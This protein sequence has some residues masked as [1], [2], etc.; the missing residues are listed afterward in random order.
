M[1]LA[2]RFY[3][4]MNDPDRIEPQ[5]GQYVSAACFEDYALN[6]FVRKNLTAHNC[7][8]YDGQ[9]R[10]PK[11]AE[12]DVVIQ[13]VF[14]RL[15]SRYDDATSGVGWDRGFVGAETY[16]SDDLVREHVDLTENAKEA[17]LEDIIGELPDRT[18]S[19]I[20]PYRARVHSVYSWSWDK[21]VDVVKHKRRYFFDV[22]N[23]ALLDEEISPHQLLA[24]VANKC[25]QA[26]MLR[27]L[28]IG[29]EFFR[30]RPSEKDQHFDTPLDLGP[31][32]KEYAAQNRMSPAGIPMF[33]G[34]A[35]N[36]T[37][38]AETLNRLKDPHSMALFALGREVTVLDLT[39]AP[40]ISIFDSRRQSLYDWAIFMHR[41]RR[42]LSKKIE[43]DNRVHIEY[44]P[45]Q[46]VTEYFR[47][48]LRAR[49]G[50]LIDG[51]LYQ[52]ATH[53]KGKCIALF[54][55]SDD[56]EPLAQ[57]QVD[58]A[59]GHLLQLLSVAQQYGSK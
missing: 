32:P 48:F 43:K 1:G 51:I 26:R 31:A 23:E 38:Q 52:S 34:A 25:R 21:L 37:A 6:K 45:T 4:E 9:G 28:P 30:C 44:I 59:S 40:I 14:E 3:E 57:K 24:T 11:G 20:D 17:L 8:Y 53:T 58:P 18:W 13:F 49:G 7:S 22:S 55:D 56:V 2:K 33:Y 19:E 36:E 39:T 27:K 50:K 12:L 47:T 41:F 29:S 5:P 15:C 10:H 42:D 54:A 46:V 35:D 16:D